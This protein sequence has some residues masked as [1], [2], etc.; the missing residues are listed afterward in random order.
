ML[1]VLEETNRKKE[2]YIDPTSRTMGSDVSRLRYENFYDDLL[3]EKRLV[4]GNLFIKDRKMEE[5]AGFGAFV[6]CVDKSSSMNNDK[7]EKA[8]AVALF[9]GIQALRR[10]IPFV[11]VVFENHAQGTI[12]TPTG[13]SKDYLELIDAVSYHLKRAL[14][15]TD[16]HNAIKKSLEI[17]DEARIFNADLLFISDGEPG[18]YD[19]TTREIINSREIFK[20]RVFIGVGFNQGEWWKWRE[21]FTK[22]INTDAKDFHVKSAISIDEIIKANT[23]ENYFSPNI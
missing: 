23:E 14:G 6:M 19:L 10:N 8:R 15:G 21:Y 18:S 3:F 22:I 2:E 13:L 1:K 4:E 5:N 16:Y 9:Y 7:I 17:L 20:N 11:L 12:I